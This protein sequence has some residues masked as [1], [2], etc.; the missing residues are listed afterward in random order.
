[1]AASRKAIELFS[2]VAI[3]GAI[4]VLVLTMGVGVQMIYSQGPV[5]YTTIQ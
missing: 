3:V 4:Y 5:T 2:I 1:M